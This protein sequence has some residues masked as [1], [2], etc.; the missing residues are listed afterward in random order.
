M[1]QGAVP[2]KAGI[3]MMATYRSGTYEGFIALF[4]KTQPSMPPDVFFGCGAG[5]RARCAH[6]AAC[7]VRGAGGGKSRYPGAYSRSCF[8]CSNQRDRQPAGVGGADGGGR[9]V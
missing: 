7:P 5:I 2:C 9:A 1:S 6:F 3:S 8:G 4:A